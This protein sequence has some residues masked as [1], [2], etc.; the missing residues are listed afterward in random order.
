MVVSQT[1]ITAYIQEVLPSLGDRQKK[2]YYALKRLVYAS[3]SMIAQHLGWSINRVTPRVYE[4]RQKGLVEEY[5]VLPCVITKRK[6]KYWRCVNGGW[7][8]ISGY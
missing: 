2:V 8:K 4:L 7:R 3:N 5:A 6:V 1:S